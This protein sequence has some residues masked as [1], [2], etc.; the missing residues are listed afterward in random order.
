VD[1]SLGNYFTTTV[2][3]NTT[4]VFSNIPAGAYSFTIQVLYSAP[5]GWTLTWP[6]A[7]KWANGI[8]PAPNSGTYALI[9]FTTADSGS[10]LFGAYLQNFA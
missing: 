1:C 3:G 9:M 8:T 10:T 4:F 6:A 5:G 7:V 2:A